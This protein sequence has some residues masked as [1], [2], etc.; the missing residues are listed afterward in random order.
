MPDL[1]RPDGTT[2]HYEVAGGG[3]PLFLLA[4]G[5][6]NSEARLWDERW[7]G[8]RQALATNHTV[9]SMDQRYAGASTG[10]NTPFDYEHVTADHL[11]VLEAIG[12]DV[13]IAVGVEIGA[14]YALRLACTAPQQVHAALVVSPMAR[15][16]E[17]PPAGYRLFEETWRVMRADG[18]E[19]VI[20]A[21]KTNP[22]FDEAPAGGP[23]AARLAADDEFASETLRKGRERYVIRVVRFRDGMFPADSTLFS[24]GQAGIEGCRAPVDIAGGASELFPAISAGLV[25]NL[26]QSA[27]IVQAPAS[28]EGWLS[29]ITSLEERV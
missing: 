18:L 26:C 29:A 5:V 16:A 1:A 23:Y 9:I 10:P 13:A 11:A 3:S 4:P 14:N 20:H 27:R 25:A 6:V 24:V 15:D 2:I 21:A 7:P 19:A 12:A 28:V 22:R 8:I 17:R